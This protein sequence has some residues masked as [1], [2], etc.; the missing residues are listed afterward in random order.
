MIDFPPLPP[1]FLFLAGALLVP[2]IKPVLR[3][4]FLILLA[5]AAL[6]AVHRLP[7]DPSTSFTTSFLPGFEPLEWLR[8]DGLSKA[9]GYIFAINALAVFIYAFYVRQATQHASALIYIGSALGTIFAGDLITAYINWEIMAVAST[10]LILSNGTK[11]SSAAAFR[12]LLLHIVSGLLFLAGLVFTASE[13]GSFG[14]DRFDPHTAGPGAWL[15]LLGF[16]VNAAAPPLHAWLSDAYPEA[17]ITG[18]VILSAYTTKTA[19]YT[20]LRGFPE[21][22]I[23]IWVG[24]VMAIYGVIYALLQND[25]RRILA[26]SII[27]QVGFKVCAAGIG[28][29]QAIS[30]AVAHAFCG[31]IY[32]SLLWMSAGAVI[33][34]TKTSLASDLGGLHRTMPWT[35]FWGFIGAL[36]IAAVPFTSG[37]TSKTI[38]IYAAEHEQL[39]WPWLVLEMASAG[40]ILYAGIKFIYHVF[41]GQDTHQLRPKEAP[42]CMHLGMLV[43]ASLCIYLGC[44]PERLYQILPFDPHYQPYTVP[45]LITQF[46]LILLATLAGFLFL[47]LLKPSK[48]IYL[49]TDWLWTNGGRSFFGVCDRGLNGLLKACGKHVTGG[50]IRTMARLFENLPAALGS[51]MLTFS[52]PNRS[53]PGGDHGEAQP[54]PPD[55]RTI[56]I[57]L[58]VVAALLLLVILTIL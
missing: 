43:M 28:T 58:T 36:T 17:S 6:Y 5:A 45:H 33:Y 41:F 20:L 13:S 29:E 8:V 44:Y 24:C 57:G 10:V 21:W 3:S 38:I 15:I 9:F 26:Y 55:N 1:G 52:R 31:I 2:L 22:E 54:S 25:I 18:G 12:Y 30:G 48:S 39:F 53:S 50:T 16:L 19:V 46:Q 37:F 32:T 47:P 42:L 35:F 27:N 23:L 7:A 51:A 40:V 49:D 11:R 14:F 4:P 34:R 56:P